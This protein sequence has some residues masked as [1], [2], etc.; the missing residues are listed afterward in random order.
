MS[1]K[2]R[3]RSWHGPGKFLSA[4]SALSTRLRGIFGPLDCSGNTLMIQSMEQL[5]LAA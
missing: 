4:W 2:L 1:D 5:L 3:G